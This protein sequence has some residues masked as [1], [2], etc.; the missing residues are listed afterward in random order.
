MLILQ[1][2][3]KSSDNARYEG[4]TKDQ[5]AAMAK[6]QMQVEMDTII[7]IKSIE[8]FSQPTESVLFYVK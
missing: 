7:T 1:H 3:R 6:E 5:M 2:Q 8:Q 4:F